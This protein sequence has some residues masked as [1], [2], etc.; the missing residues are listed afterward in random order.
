M[1]IQMFFRKVIKAL[2]MCCIF[3]SPTSF[4][5]SHL[6]IMTE[7]WPPLNY[8]EGK[9]AVGPAVELVEQA[10][11][12]LKQNSKIAILPW[13]RAY[14]EVLNTKNTMLFSMSRTKE[15]E[16]LFKWVGPIAAKKYAFFAKAGSNIKLSNIES[17]KAYRIGVQ[18]G[19]VTEE[20]IKSQNFTKVDPILKTKQNLDKLLNGRINL[21][22][23]GSSTVYDTLKKEGLPENTVEEVLVA[24][25]QHLYM[26]FN[27][28]TLQKEID[29]WQQ[30]LLTLYKNGEMEK[31]YK[32]YNALHLMPN[33][34]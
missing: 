21:W 33:L 18:N 8:R 34:D 16:N 25:T 11:K 23:E 30:A 13:K 6:N 5:Q 2:L 15:R 28:E 27:K 14:Q 31:I 17:A 10:Q 19:G 12:I 20:Y 1:E 4:A 22:Y 26:A 3:L 7:D 29:Q 32:K 9:V 24:K